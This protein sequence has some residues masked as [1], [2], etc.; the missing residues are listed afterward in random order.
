MTTTHRTVADRI[1]AVAAVL[2]LAALLAGLPVILAVAGDVLITLP[3]L[4]WPVLDDS[5]L[6][7]PLVEQLRPWLE[8]TWHT[9]RLDLGVDGALTLA[10]LGVGWVSWFV[11]LWWSVCDLLLL[12]RFGADVARQRLARVGPRGWITGLVAAAIVASAPSNVSATPVSPPVAVTAPQYP[13]GVGPAPHG[14]DTTMRLGSGG[15]PDLP[16]PSTPDAI[17]DDIRP[18]CPRYRVTRGD[19]LWGLAARHLGDPHRWH[20][21]LD[22]NADRIGDGEYLLT[23]WILLLPPDATHLPAPVAIPDDARWI[24]V[25]PDDT[26]TTIAERELGDPDRWREIADLNTHQ[27]QADGRVLRDPDI[28]LPGWRLALPPTTDHMPVP[29]HSGN[30]PAEPT[31]DDL[32]S[33]LESLGPSIPDTAAPP[34][35][36]PGVELASGVFLG[37]G[38]AAAASA[39]LIIARQRHRRAHRPGTTPPPDYPV[40]PTVYQLKL[41]HS[42]ATQPSLDTA[43]PVDPRL[44][45]CEESEETTTEPGDVIVE[46]GASDTG[47]TVQL[48][49]AAT[50]GLGLTGPGAEGAMRPVVLGLQHRRRRVVVQRTVADALFPNQAALPPP[51]E[52]TDDLDTALD[53]LTARDGQRDVLVVSSPLQSP[54]A[55]LRTRV[56][57][58]ASGGGLVVLALGRWPAG[59]TLTIDA[60]GIVDSTTPDAAAEHLLGVR[61][62]TAT[63]HAADDLLALAHHAGPHTRQ[64]T[65]TAS[66]TPATAGVH[67]A[68][69]DMPQPAPL[70]RESTPDADENSPSPGDGAAAG[71]STGHSGIGRTPGPSGDVSDS[72][73]AVLALRVLGE[74]ALSCNDD[75]GIWRDLSA[76]LAPRQR[77][78]LTYL[79]VHPDGVARDSL[80][81]DLWHTSPPARPTNALHTALS[82]LRATLTHA[83]H[84][85]AGDIVDTH[86][87][88]LRLNPDLVKVDYHRFA[89]AEHSLRR[90]QNTTQRLAALREIVDSYRSELG[91]GIDSEWIHTT[92]H[93]TQR[94][95]INAISEL[96]RHHVADDPRHTLELLET[97]TGFDPYNEHLYRDIMRLQDRLGI[98]D[99]I[100]RTLALLE[101]RL[102]DINCEPAQETQALASA[103]Q[104]RHAQQVIRSVPKPPPPETGGRH[105]GSLHRA[106]PHPG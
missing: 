17:D 34:V 47:D 55:G 62:F 100:P 91:E 51:L 83:T 66:R 64:A 35:R 29:A 71:P 40:P 30:A 49:V 2:G 6:A 73:S 95:A 41:A 33:S 50:G 3:N 102:R 32:A 70:P 63:P 43:E 48:N 105:T 81:T 85:R 77:E 5:T 14:P 103:L 60:N 54:N 20:E 9:L 36:G 87:R 38:L 13:G 45:V 44:P 78:L 8:N 23:G 104:H 97:A 37:L 52:V 1:R 53:D 92:R 15:Y 16:E 106:A 31:R 74:F 76:E 21:I 84:G 18:D 68:G 58:A 28:L 61:M 10:L 88:H 39:A 79:A 96:A 94:T 27:P 22:L 7:P 99:G 86:N 101:T 46:L 25:Q 82:R 59:T 4:T 12:V 80:I 67:A 56:H 24:T 65:A 57:A 72:G 75:R 69:H 42:R 98:H 93:A 89:H 26:L 11:M 90:T 19:T